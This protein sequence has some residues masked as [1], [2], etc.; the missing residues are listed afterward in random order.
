MEKKNSRRTAQTPEQRLYVTMMI[1]VAF[2]LLCGLGI[3]LALDIRRNRQELDRMIGDSAAYIADQENV[4]KMLQSGY[5]DQETIASLDSFVDSFGEIDAVLIANLNGL[6]FYQTNRLTVGDVYTNGDEKAILEGSSPYITRVYGTLGAKYC[7]FHS[8]KNG[9][10]NITGFVMVSVPASRIS[11]STRNIVL[12]YTV[13]FFTMLLV[14]ALAAHAFLGFQRN[15]LL[16][17][18]PGEL[19]SLYI[20]QDEVIN[21]ISEGLVS[22]DRNGRILFSNTAARKL[23]INDETLLTGRQLPEVLP[24]TA[25]QEVIAGKGSRLNRTMQIGGRTVLVSEVPIRSGGKQHPEGVLVILQDRTEALKMS[26]ELTGARNMMD[27]LRAFN[28]EFL[29]KLHIILGYLQTGEIEEAKRFIT[30]SSLVSSKSVRDTANAIRV[31]EV[32]AL[33]IGKMMHAAELGI[34]LKIEPDST[35]LEQDLLVPKEAFVTIIGNLLENAIE[36]LNGG[37][38]EAREIRLGVICAPDANIITCEDTGG[39]IREE[40]LPRI[41][42]KGVT[43]KGENHGTGLFLVKQLADKYGGEIEIE[44]EEGEGTCFTVTFSGRKEEENVLSGDDR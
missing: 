37:Q 4:K 3:T 6:R 41:F 44:T 11:Q 32:C 39:G 26:D 35:M 2:V 28:H 31:P 17:H 36:E 13:L 8:I 24:Q 23:I 22:A 7:A 38:T 5:P 34:I 10:G 16:G 15:A 43:S 21:S 9:A 18:R 33:V 25:F 19:L 12:L 27:T 1:M 20:R 30:N 42:E 40:I 14:S 29:N